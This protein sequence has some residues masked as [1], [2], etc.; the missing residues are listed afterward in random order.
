MLTHHYALFPSK[1]EYFTAINT[2]CLDKILKSRL[3]VRALCLAFSY[4]C[5]VLNMSEAPPAREKRLSTGAHVSGS[6]GNYYDNP[7]PN[8]G[9]RKR[10][11]IY[12]TV[13]GA[14]GP[15]SIGFYLIA[16][17]LLSV[18]LTPFVSSLPH[19]LY[20]LKSS[21]LLFHKWKEGGKRAKP[22]GLW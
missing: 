14:C 8:I 5:G 9:R 4:L 13:Q 7:D 19:L 10:Q 15:I 16:A 11:R 6:F 20:H 22:Q 12:G 21:R 3:K 17:K 2:S 1:I 18:S